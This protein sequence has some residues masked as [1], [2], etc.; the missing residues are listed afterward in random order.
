ME[1]LLGPVVREIIPYSFQD[2]CCGASLTMSNLA[3]AYQI[4][5]TRLEELER[6][7]T[8]VIITA[9]GNCQLLLDR[10]Q[11]AYYNGRKIPCLFLPQVLGIAMG[12]TP[13]EL[14][15]NDSGVRS[16]VSGV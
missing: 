2:R 1:E 14:M 5:R 8:D 3:A 11:S 16:L 12:F 15:I 6:K 10:K 7:D 9:C 13:E 4:G